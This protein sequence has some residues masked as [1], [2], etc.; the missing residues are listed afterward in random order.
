MRFRSSS[1]KPVPHRDTFHPLPRREKS[2]I[3]TGL[4]DLRIPRPQNCPA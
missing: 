1:R 3:D 4:S 2:H